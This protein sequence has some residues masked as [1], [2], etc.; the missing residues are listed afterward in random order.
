MCKNW[1]TVELILVSLVN[2]AASSLNWELRALGKCWC[3]EAWNGGEPTGNACREWWCNGYQNQSWQVGNIWLISICLNY[4]YCSFN[5]STKALMEM[6]VTCNQYKTKL[7]LH[8]SAKNTVRVPYNTVNHIL[9][10]SYHTMKGHPNNTMH[11]YT[12][13]I[14]RRQH[15]TNIHLSLSPVWDKIWTFSC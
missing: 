3:F 14:D 8:T 2:L 6:T 13:L 9:T 15:K 10:I 4:I 7:L 12:Q 1:P 11:S 5:T